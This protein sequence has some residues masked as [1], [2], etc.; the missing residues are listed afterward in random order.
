MFRLYSKNCSYALKALSALPLDAINGSFT[1]TWLCQKA[2]VPESFTRKALQTLSQA[3]YLRTVTGPKGGYTFIKH[4]KDI[5][6]LELIK[7]LEGEDVYDECI[8]GLHTCND[9]MPCPMHH[10]WKG[11]KARMQKT[12]GNK[13]L[14]HLIKANMN[15]QQ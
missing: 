9:D 6:I 11:M 14:A 15:F 13:T 8:L 1:A 2:D 5:S 10:T 7:V 4:P 3:G 12:L